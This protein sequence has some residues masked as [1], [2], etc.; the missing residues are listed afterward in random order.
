MYYINQVYILFSLVVLVIVV[1]S[2]S[3]QCIVSLPE[4]RFTKQVSVP[5]VLGTGLI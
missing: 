4:K 5:K 3:Y 2:K 1:T